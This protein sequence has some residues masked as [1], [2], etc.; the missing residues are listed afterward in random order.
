MGDVD[1]TSV[2]QGLDTPVAVV[3]P[4]Q[5]EILFENGRFF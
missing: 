5:W 2:L 4:K 3:S 1:I